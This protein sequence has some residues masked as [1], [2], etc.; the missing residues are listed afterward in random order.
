MNPISYDYIWPKIIRIK[1]KFITI[2][3]RISI[4]NNHLKI[5]ACDKHHFLRVCESISSSLGQL[6]VATNQGE[7]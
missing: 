3:V 1:K 4:A 5:P 2:D 7:R 6:K